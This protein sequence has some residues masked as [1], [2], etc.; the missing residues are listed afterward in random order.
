VGGGYISVEFAG[1]FHGLGTTVT[2]AYRGPLF[3]RGF[4]TDVREF[5]AGQMRNQGIDLR[6]DTSVTSIAQRS[7]GRLDCC[8]SGGERLTVDSL[9]FATGRHPLTAD[10]GLEAAGVE[11][12]E[13]GAIR[14]DAQYRT[15]IPS[16][17]AVGDVTDRV[18]LTPVALAEGMTVARRLFGGLDQ[19]VD[20]EYIPSAVFSAP[21][22][23]TVGLSEDEARHRGLPVKIFRS[24]FRP[25]IHTLS[26]RNQRTL[27]KLVVHADSDRV[28]GCHMVG[29]EAGEI[30][31]GFA[32][33]MR[34]GATKRVFDTTVGIHPTAAEEFVTMRTPTR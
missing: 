9:L 15:N 3:M 25:M 29:P 31:Q 32:V 12:N 34:A 28:L 13:K 19:V 11:S 7:D 8:I 10:L 21:P 18:N 6:F 33:A 2:Q 5:L 30:I 26:G 24:D 22:V 27:M 17:Y 1:I 20:Y 14:V 16:V 23:G 4:D